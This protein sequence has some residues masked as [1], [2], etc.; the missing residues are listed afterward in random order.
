MAKDVR[1][2]IVACITTKLILMDRSARLRSQ[3]KH[4]IKD[5]AHATLGGRGDRHG[6]WI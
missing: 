3:F 5:V 2:L 4:N 1:W 6:K